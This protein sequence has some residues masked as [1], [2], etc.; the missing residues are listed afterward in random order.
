M[1]TIYARTDHAGACT[2]RNVFHPISFR[3]CVEH[4]TLMH[5]RDTLIDFS[6]TSPFWKDNL[7]PSTTCDVVAMQISVHIRL[8]MWWL[9]PIVKLTSIQKQ[10]LLSLYQTRQAFVQNALAVYTAVRMAYD[11]A[12]GFG[13]PGLAAIF[14]LCSYGG[15]V[16]SVA[17]LTIACLQQCTSA[18]I[19]IYFTMPAWHQ[20][21]L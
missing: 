13:L 4:S 16:T 20:S 21:T 15:A 14:I 19:S 12:T 17:K 11:C 1:H 9:C 5:E 7:A 2:S 18:F 6:Q 10:G 3:S 8:I